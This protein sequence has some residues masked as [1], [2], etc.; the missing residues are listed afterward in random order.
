MVIRDD[1]VR[2]GRVLLFEAHLENGDDFAFVVDV[3]NRIVDDV[4][5]KLVGDR[6]DLLG[7]TLDGPVSLS[8]RETCSEFVLPCTLRKLTLGTR[9]VGTLNIADGL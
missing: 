6:L 1:S 3:E 2:I 5:K 9:S 4:F 8:T 7:L